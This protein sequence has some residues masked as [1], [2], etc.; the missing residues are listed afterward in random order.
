MQLE[1]P[2]PAPRPFPLRAVDAHAR[3]LVMFGAIWLAVGS[4]ISVAFTAAGGPFW[5]DLLL[6]RRGVTAPAKMGLIEPTN[7]SVNGRLVYRVRYIFVDRNGVPRDGT[8]S[9][10]DPASFYGQTELT[11][12]YDPLAPA[13]TRLAG[14]SASFFGLFVLFPFAFAVVGAIVVGFG[15]RRAA[16][17]RAIYVHGHPVQAKVT[18]VLP[19]AMRINHRRVM[20]V[21]YAFETIMGGA[22]GSTSALAPPP[23]GSPLWVLHLP[24]D[25]KRNVAF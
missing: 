4:I 9:T 5:D 17:T 25:P 16:A 12:Q 1:M 22:T 13:R 21:E 11:I 3:F 23:V 20:R 8:G 14:G 24:S 18:A 10:T 6:D 19:S 15:L 7:S 2:P